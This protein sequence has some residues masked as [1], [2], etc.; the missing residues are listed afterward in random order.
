MLN[1]RSSIAELRKV[2]RVETN[3]RRAFE[4]FTSG[5]NQWWPLATHSVGELQAADVAFGTGVGGVIV[6]TLADGTTAAWVTVT[7]WDPPRAVAFTWHPGNPE[8][9]AGQVEVTFMP[10]GS[11]GTLVELVHT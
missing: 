8:S 2:V 7:R 5:I 1:Q 6:E 11:G 3:P 4:L 10:E 9:Q